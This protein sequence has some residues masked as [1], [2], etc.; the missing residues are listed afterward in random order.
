MPIP[1]KREP[2]MKIH[3]PGRIWKEMLSS[4]ESVTRAEFDRRNKAPQRVDQVEGEIAALKEQIRELA[5]RL[6]KKD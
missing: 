2:T 3:D 6:P 1:Q 5:S 4:K